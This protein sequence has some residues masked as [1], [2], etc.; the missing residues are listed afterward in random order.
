MMGASCDRRSFYMSF[1]ENLQFLR[2][3]AGLTQEDLAE[4]MEVSRQS[5]SKWESNSAYPEMDA[6]L[7]LCD[8]FGVDMDTLL[9]G[10]VSLRFM[11]DA[12]GYDKHMNAFSRAIAGGVGLILLGVTV[13]V[14]LLTGIQGG[15]NAVILPITGTAILLIFIT[16]S[17]AIFIVSGMGHDRFR[18]KHPTLQPFYTEEQLDAYE[19]R[20]PLLI[21][22]PI[23]LILTGVVVQV[24]IVLVPE[25]SDMG[26]PDE[27]ALLGTAVLLFCVTV[28]VPVLVWA[29]IQKEKY[30]IEAYNRQNQ[31]E[32]D[33]TPEQKR[34][35]QLVSAVWGV[36][37]ILA[38]ALFLLL[39][40]TRDLWNS[41][42][43][44]YPV[45]ALLCAAITVFL[46]RKDG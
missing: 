11:E 43:A 38:T 40:F 42:G 22:L 30:D 5:V 20:F 32:F 31:Q 10:D 14:A 7:R 28:A 17:V 27:W 35:N 1:G 24:A 12:A 21:A 33:P 26:S 23:V 37:M 3:R 16:I 4:Q 13:L 46:K 45:A 6:I 9:R 8:R 36:G 18:K 25:L 19:R 29:G 15:E 39:G 41:A 2:K 34:L 44:V